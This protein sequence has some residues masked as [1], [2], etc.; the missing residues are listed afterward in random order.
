MILDQRRQMS[1]NTITQL[2]AQQDTKTHRHLIYDR[3]HCKLSH[4]Y[5]KNWSL[6]HIMKKSTSRF[7][8]DLNT[9]S[10]TLTYLENTREYLIILKIQISIN[11]KRVNSHIPKKKKYLW[12]LWCTSKIPLQGN[13]CG[14]NYWEY[15]WPSA[16]SYQTLQGLSQLEN[17]LVQSHLPYW[18]GHIQ[19]LT[20][21]I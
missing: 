5:E 8:Q 19:W 15:C 14:P 7:I 16:F 17:C 18:V 4:L 3:R 1:Q 6:P 13:I 2:M 12:T 21:P 11:R 10:K 20:I 9:N